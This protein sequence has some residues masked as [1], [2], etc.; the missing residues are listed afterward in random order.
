MRAMI[1]KCICAWLFLAIC[2]PSFGQESDDPNAVRLEARIT[3]YVAAYNKGDAEALADFWSEQG[4]YTTLAG[5]TLRG[6]SEIS[7]KFKEWF[8]ESGLGQLELVDPNVEIQSPSVAIE[9]GTARVTI[10]DQETTETG[11]RAILVNTSAGWKIDGVSEYELEPVAPSNFDRLQE[12]EWMV[13]SWTRESEESNVEASCR[14]TT[15]QN[16]LLQT[17]RVTSSE[18][19]ILEVSQIIGWDPDAETI[20]SWTFDSDGGFSAG[21]W[22]GG[23]GRWTCQS[24]SVLPDGRRG[25]AT[26]I[27][28]RVDENSL[29]YS[30]IGRQVDGEL[31]PNV[32]PVEMARIIESPDN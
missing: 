20:R 17:Y 32:E 9:T 8:S 28:E 1:T 24:L 15:N 27:Y 2:I 13:G 12:L 21:R 26:N 30:S 14:W 4:E 6:R 10:P 31:I 19:G 22:N 25:S 29:R 5:Q 11:Y 3:G 16:F 23:E 18:G 7:A